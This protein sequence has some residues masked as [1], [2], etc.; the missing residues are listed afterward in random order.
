MVAGS[1][2]KLLNFLITN[3]IGIAVV[4]L[5]VTEL[6]RTSLASHRANPK[7]LS[8]QESVQMIRAF[9]GQV[10]YP[11]P[12]DKELDPALREAAFGGP[13]KAPSG[14]MLGR[15]VDRI[16]RFVGL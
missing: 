13:K 3:V 2:S 7:M 14:T 4:V 11:K 5:G 9:H 15:A 16:A 12:V 10:S 1:D 8:Q 6:Q